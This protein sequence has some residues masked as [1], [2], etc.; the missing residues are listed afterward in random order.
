MQLLTSPPKE[1]LTSVEAIEEEFWKRTKVV[2]WP[3]EGGQANTKTCPFLTLLSF[4]L[5]CIACV[6]QWGQEALDHL[7]RHPFNPEDS[8]AG[9]L[10]QS[11]YASSAMRLTGLVLMRQFMLNKRDRGFYIARAIQV[12]WMLQG[13]IAAHYMCTLLISLL[14]DAAAVRDPGAHRWVAVCY[15]PSHLQRWAP[16]DGA[17]V[18]V[19]PGWRRGLSL[20]V[21]SAFHPTPLNLLVC[22]IACRPWP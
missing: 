10:M 2:L 19:H 20:I 22:F 5:L 9:S 16:S 13:S 8:T 4:L 21:S 14:C 6:L 3:K 1:L 15:H 7:D 12:S 17:G 11:H 18:A